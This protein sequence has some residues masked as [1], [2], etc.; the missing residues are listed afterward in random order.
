MALPPS[1]PNRLADLITPLPWLRW[2]SHSSLPLSIARDENGNVFEAQAGVGGLVASLRAAVARSDRQPSND[3]RMN[4]SSASTIPTRVVGLS[5]AASR[6]N[7]VAS[8][9]LWSVG[10]RSAVRPSPPTGSFDHR[11]RLVEPPLCVACRKTGVVDALWLT[12]NVTAS[13]LFTPLQPTR[14]PQSPP[15]GP[16]KV[17]SA[18]CST[19]HSTKFVNAPEAKF[20]KCRGSVS[21]RP[22]HF[23][24][25]YR[26]KVPIRNRGEWYNVLS[27]PSSP[28]FYILA[29]GRACYG[30]GGRILVAYT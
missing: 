27:P 6:E 20:P 4:L 9:T 18:G 13:L 7:V 23:P 24:I 17:D 29:P 25:E 3:S 15:I 16:V 12:V 21:Q 8:G 2:R 1:Q 11:V 10:H 26:K 22:Q 30:T 28:S 19:S 5:S 14:P